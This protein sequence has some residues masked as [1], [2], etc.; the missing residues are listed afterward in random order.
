MHWY[1]FT[2]TTPTYP[3]DAEPDIEAVEVFATEEEARRFASFLEGS[4]AKRHDPLDA[5]AWIRVV[6]HQVPPGEP[7]EWWL[8]KQLRNEDQ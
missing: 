1:V 7:P 8:A 6:V 5:S 2:V 3:A 4:L